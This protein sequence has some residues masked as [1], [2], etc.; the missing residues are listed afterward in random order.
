MAAF[1][2]LVVVNVAVLCLAVY[3]AVRTRKIDPLF[4]ESKN[5]GVVIYITSFFVLLV[6]AVTGAGDTVSNVVSDFFVTISMT[7][8]VSF[9][10]I[11][12]YA[13]KLLRR[14]ANA[15]EPQFSLTQ[16]TRSVST[17]SNYV[18]DLRI[19]LS[20]MTVGQLSAK[21]AEHQQIVTVIGQVLESKNQKAPNT[22][23]KP[24][25]SNA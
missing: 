19:T 11:A 24:N 6:L 1:V 14:N 23:M 13:Q 10:C 7:F 8:A 5:L 21:L 12:L 3:F 22:N 20:G 9:G 18:H 25:S 15:V 4:N 2:A 17:P 16:I